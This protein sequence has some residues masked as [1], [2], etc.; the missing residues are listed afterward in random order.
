MQGWTVGLIILGVL[1]VVLGFF[2]LTVQVCTW[3]IVSPDGT[4][5][6]RWAPAFLFSGSFT[7]FFGILML[8]S[9]GYQAYA[10]M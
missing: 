1:T 6:V 8:V 10:E 2:M 5:C 3:A 7:I 4:E 9:G